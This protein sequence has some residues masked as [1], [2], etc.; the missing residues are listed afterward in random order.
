MFRL[1]SAVHSL[2]PGRPCTADNRKQPGACRK[3]PTGPG[4]FIE[5][6]EES[7]RLVFS[8]ADEVELLG[9]NGDGEVFLGR[10]VEL[11]PDGAVGQVIVPAGLCGLPA[12]ADDVLGKLLPIY[13]G[14]ERTLFLADQLQGHAL[15]RGFV[16]ALG[17]KAD[18][19]AV[20]G[21]EG[22]GGLGVDSVFVVLGVAVV[23][24]QHKAGVGL[25]GNQ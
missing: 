25:S 6:D 14:P 19:G 9:G 18:V 1:I 12:V 2:P 13:A 10:L 3:I 22:D 24:V 20:A 17:G 5:E 7:V 11:D 21:L 23:I 15:H 4:P 8:H 16:A